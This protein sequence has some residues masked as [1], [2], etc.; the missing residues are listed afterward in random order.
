[1]VVV[2]VPYAF[3]VDSRYAEA[4][5]PH[6][7]R[8]VNA[9]SIPFFAYFVGGAASVAG[10][11]LA[12]FVRQ[13]TTLPLKAGFITHAGKGPLQAFNALLW[14]AWGTFALPILAASLVAQAPVSPSQGNATL[15][16][17]NAVTVAVVLI[18]V[19]PTVVFP[20]VLMN[21]WLARHK[22]GELRQ[23]RERLEE[24]AAP[25]E[26][27]SA[28][29]VSR[30]LLYHLHMTQQMQQIQGFVSTLVDARFVAQIG[31]SITAAILANILLRAVVF[32]LI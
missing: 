5:I 2:S 32:K 22:A 25:P 16:A 24:T 29:E 23:V 4:G 1:M 3:L 13:M 15:V 12:L 21:R 28:D 20:Q 30:R 17:L 7:S 19:I 18:L 8:I 10:L 9:L 27:A 11:G 14:E 31:T 6:V 26:H